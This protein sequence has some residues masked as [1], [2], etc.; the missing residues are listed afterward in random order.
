MGLQFDA[1]VGRQ[2][3]HRPRC[4]GQLPGDVV[5]DPR[6]VTGERFA[7]WRHGDAFHSL[8]RALGGRI[9]AAER[10]DLAAE[11]FDAHRQGVGWREDIEDA[12]PMAELARSIHD[13][14]RFEAQPCP[15]T[16]GPLQ[17]QRLARPELVN[18]DAELAQWQRALHQRTGR[19]NDDHLL[20]MGG[21]VA[22]T[23]R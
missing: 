8:L 19:R 11:E 2:I 5:G 10:L 18:G 12:T 6:A 22:C 21:S 13:A 16:Q 1:Y 9:K 15:T 3:V 20:S 23:K 4:P 7:G 17:V 14:D